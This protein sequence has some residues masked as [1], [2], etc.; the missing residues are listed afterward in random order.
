[1]TFLERTEVTTLRAT[2]QTQRYC[3]GVDVLSRDDGKMRTIEADFVVDASG[4]HSR[5]AAWLR[6]LD[7]ELPEDDVIDGY[8]GF[9]RTHPRV[10]DVAAQASESS[11]RNVSFSGS[12]GR[13]R[14]WLYIGNAGTTLVR[15]RASRSSHRL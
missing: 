12:K 4:T 5:A 1:V 7:L 2:G 11:I 13:L 6:R 15:R 3:T 8:S 9:G 14:S 10:R